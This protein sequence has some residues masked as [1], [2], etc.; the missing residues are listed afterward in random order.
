MMRLLVALFALTAPLVAGEPGK[1]SYRKQVMVDPNYTSRWTKEDIDA[2][3]APPPPPAEPVAEKP[4][5]EPA[6][7]PVE[8]APRV[9]YVP[10]PVWT[11]A[12]TYVGY[13]SGWS[14]C[15][16]RWGW[17]WGWGIGFGWGWGHHH[18]GHHYRGCR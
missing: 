14:P 5:A 16:P 13:S 17:G 11:P 6:P 18:H 12:V 8:E 1:I 3:L 15:Y 10:E 9:E 2:A 4:A 7:A